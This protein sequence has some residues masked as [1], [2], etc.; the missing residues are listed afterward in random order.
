MPVD[1]LFRDDKDFLPLQAADLYAWVL[2][3]A[4]NDPSYKEYHWLL[5]ELQNVKTTDYSQ[6]YD[7][8][9]MQSVMVQMDDFIRD[10]IPDDLLKKF[11][12]HRQEHSRGPPVAT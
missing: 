2:R 9:R 6:Y 1:V 8:E 10:G 4:N 11:R 5:D 3:K 7:L 12:K